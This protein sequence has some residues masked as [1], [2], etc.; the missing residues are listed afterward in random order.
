METE[1]QSPVK[2]SLPERDKGRHEMQRQNQSTSG[3]MD[4][5]SLP[6]NPS[7]QLFEKSHDKNAGSKKRSGGY[8]S[9]NTYNVKKCGVALPKA[10]RLISPIAVQPPSTSSTVGGPSMLNRSTGDFKKDFSS[11]GTYR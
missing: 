5:P 3:R 6:L 8:G 4:P 2:M 7:S 1:V 10:S 11:F 9:S